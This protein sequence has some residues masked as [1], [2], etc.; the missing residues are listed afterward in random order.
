[1]N[2][3]PEEV[4]VAA[5]LEALRAEVRAQRAAEGEGRSGSHLSAVEREL[6]RCAE[7]IEITRVVSAHWPLEGRSLYERGWALV[8][9]VVRRYLR[10]Y[11]NPIVEQQNA[12]N[13]VGARSIR[14]L[15]EANAELRDE[16]DDLRR[17]LDQMSPAAPAPGDVPPPPAGDAPPTAE[18][19]G[20][21]ERGAGAEP[22]APLPDLALRPLPTLAAERAAVSAHWDLGGDTPLGKARALAQRGVRQYLRWMI[23]PIV[24]QQSAANAAI[25][26]ALPHR[27]AAD[28]ELRAEAAALRARR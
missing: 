1:M 19:Q 23:N 9:K 6:H 16:L 17:R 8:H 15:I 13:D 14:L 18:L 11:I 28:A 12:F 5:S 21:V 24:E 4:D 27:L 7:Q 20:L 25:A 2:Q 26:E 10:W 3:L 22:L